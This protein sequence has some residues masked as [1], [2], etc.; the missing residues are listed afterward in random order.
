MF[1][2]LNI[3]IEEYNS[4]VINNE[5]ESEYNNPLTCN[6]YDIDE[7]TKCKFNSSKT[8]SIM[9]LN[10]HSIQLHIDELKNLLKMLDYTFDII[11]ISESKLKKDPIINIEIPGYKTPCITKT[12]A[13]K[14]GTLIYVLK[15]INF[16]RRKDLEIY[17]SKN[18]ESTFI[19]IINQKES[20]NI[21][22]VIYRHP[23][24]DP[25]KFIENEL[26]CL[27]DKLSQESNKKV[28]MAGDFNFDLFKIINHTAT[29]NFYEK[30]TSNLYIASFNFI[31]Y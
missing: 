17:Q 4:R 16:K 15:D 31:A 11:T 2:K 29:A 20:N 13:E 7:F 5:N 23:K 30:I 19:E 28:Y 9:H 27:L 26:S 14:G 6:Y 1:D 3:E 18:L 12:E 8:F 22:G 25:T 21:I 10:I 24:M